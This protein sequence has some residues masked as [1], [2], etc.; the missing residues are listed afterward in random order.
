MSNVYEKWYSA[1]DAGNYKQAAKLITSKN[2]LYESIDQGQNT[3]N[4]VIWLA[5]N[6]RPCEACKNRDG[7][8]YTLEHCANL[9]IH[10]HCGCKLLP[11]G[12]YIT[13]FGSINSDRSRLTVFLK[14]NVDSNKQNNG[15][16]SFLAGLQLVLDIVGLFPGLGEVAD[17]LNAL[18]YLGRG[19][20]LNAGLS[21]ASMI[22]FA[23]WTFTGGK[24]AGKGMK[25]VKNAQKAE[26]FIEGAGK[27]T[28]T[29]GIDIELMYKDGWTLTQKAEADAKVKSLTE[30]LTVKTVP[31]RSG[32][33]ASSRYKKVTGQ[34]SIPQGKDVDHIIDLQLGGTDDILNMRPLDN[35]VNR[36]LGVQIQN[37]IRN[38][39]IGTQFDNFTIK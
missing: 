35:S 1:V 19:D 33:S 34:N 30:A 4:K 23:G 24:L 14:S 22:P 21:A 12:P 36:S 27:A 7:N 38:Y 2:A 15:F 26:G 9:Q 10:P 25:I 6:N 3:F 39:P 28:N 17:G 13:A 29:K 31:N 5:N 16:A 8:V 18:I 20:V 32:T 11:L 37:K